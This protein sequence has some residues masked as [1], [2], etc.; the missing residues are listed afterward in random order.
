MREVDA[1]SHP[2]AVEL[3]K[4][5]SLPGWPCVRLTPHPASWITLCQNCA[6]PPS[7]IRTG[8]QFT[9]L[10]HC[11]AEYPCQGP[12][13]PPHPLA[14]RRAPSDGGRPSPGPV[15]TIPRD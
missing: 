12:Q 14:A 9:I 3:L 1:G 10:L 5:L 2:G 15:C 6:A 8:M 4:T 13:G 7:Y 11:C